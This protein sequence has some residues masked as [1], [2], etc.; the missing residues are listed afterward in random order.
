MKKLRL[1]SERGVKMVSKCF[2]YSLYIR[3]CWY[4]VISSHTGAEWT[5]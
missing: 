5:C 1:M 2:V 4:G 3:T